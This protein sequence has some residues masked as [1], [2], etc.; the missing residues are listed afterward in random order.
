MG[1]DSF[2]YGFVARGTVAL[3]EYSQFTGNLPAIAEQCLQRLP[4]GNNRFTYEY[5]QHSFNFLVDDGYD[6]SKFKEYDL[7][8][9][10]GANVNA[11]SDKV[12]N[13]RDEISGIEQ[14]FGGKYIRESL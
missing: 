14:S 6:R 4:S 2:V 8:I 9:E 3:A 10:R 13:L 5:D 11:L 12:E 1:Q 7:V